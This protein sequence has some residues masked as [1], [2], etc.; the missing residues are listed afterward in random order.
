MRARGKLI[1]SA[2]ILMLGVFLLAFPFLGLTAYAADETANAEGD[3]SQLQAGQTEATTQPSSETAQTSAGT[4]GSG[5]SVKAGTTTGSAT[6]ATTTSKAKRVIKKKRQT[7]KVPQE[8]YGVAVK[9]PSFTIKAK[10]KTRRSYKS[11]RPSIAKVNSKGKVTIGK[12]AGVATI[13]ITARETA[14][15]KKATKKVKIRVTAYRKTIGRLAHSAAN[16]DGRRGDRGGESS[17]RSYWDFGWNFIVRCTDPYI[18]ERAATAVRYIVGNK[19]LGYNGCFPTSQAN[20]TKRA[21]IYRAVVKATGKNPT[22]DDLKKIKNVKQYGD[23]SCTPTLLAGYWLYYD[24][25]DQLNLKWY[26]PYNK[27]AYKYYCGAP[28]VEY[29]QLETCIRAVNAKY[30]KAGKLAPF[31]IIY[32]PRANRS[33]FFSRSSVMKNLRRGDI[34]CYCPNPNR[35]GHTAM[36][37]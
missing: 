6:K 11:N 26:P 1:N 7:I 32:I 2:A 16:Y 22:Y 24:M 4:T 35:N 34:I 15:Y 9:A 21:S 12:K 25:S 19:Y 23:T 27:K 30:T 29:H 33:S 5:S 14:R 10:S 28:N 17:V 13:T 31:K 3:S 8:I 18:A 20:V 37:M 36:M